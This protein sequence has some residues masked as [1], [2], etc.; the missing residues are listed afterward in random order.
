MDL[1]LRARTAPADDLGLVTSTHIRKHTTTFK[2]SS[3]LFDIISL[4]PQVS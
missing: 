1:R 2:S 4:P 3:N